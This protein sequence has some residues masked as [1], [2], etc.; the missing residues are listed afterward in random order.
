MFLWIT[1]KRTQ[2]CFQT[3]VR[4]IQSFKLS[5]CSLRACRHIREACVT[6]CDQCRKL[7]SLYLLRDN[8]LGVEVSGNR[9]LVTMHTPVV[10]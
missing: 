4:C 7:D 6:W 3:D 2:D 1:R 10:W 9:A 8:K 5:F